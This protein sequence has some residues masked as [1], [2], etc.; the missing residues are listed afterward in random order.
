MLSFLHNVSVAKCTA[1]S[2]ELESCQQNNVDLHAELKELKEKYSEKTQELRE[3]DERCT[4]Q[5]NEYHQLEKQ[6][7]SAV[8]K[9]R[10]ALNTLKDTQK[11]KKEIEGE[12]EMLKEQLKVE[13]RKRLKLEEDCKMLQAEKEVLAQEREK[14]VQ[15]REKL[16]QD[17]QQERDKIAQERDKLSEEI[18]H[19]MD[20]NSSLNMRI[21]ALT[22]SSHKKDKTIVDLLQSIH[23]TNRQ[24]SSASESRL[25]SLQ[26]AQATAAGNHRATQNRL[27]N[28]A[29]DSELITMNPDSILPLQEQADSSEDD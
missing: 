9:H 27:H 14:I 3:K 11:G 16:V 17:S 12:N 6:H 24:H 19:L 15:E 5:N 18:K 2:S 20:V 7:K 4:E 23:T 25:Q 1:C 29:S 13:E 22:N 26:E 8:E 10:K 28:S 21:D